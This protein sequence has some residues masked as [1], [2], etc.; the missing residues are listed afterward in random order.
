[1]FAPLPVE[2]PA[3]TRLSVRMGEPS[4]FTEHVA[5][6][7]PARLRQLYDEA[8]SSG[9]QRLPRFALRQ[10]PYA[11]QVP[12]APSLLTL[13][14]PLVVDYWQHQLPSALGR[15]GV[16][17]AR[18]LTPVLSVYEE[19]FDP[20]DEDFCQFAGLIERTLLTT[21]A[22]AV[23]PLRALQESLT[24]FR[25]HEAPSRIAVRLLSATEGLTAEVSRANLS[26]DVLATRLGLASFNAA[27]SLLPAT[28]SLAQTRTERLLEW[29][30][31]LATPVERSPARAAFVEAL[32][33]PWCDAPPPERLKRQ[34]SETLIQRL[35]D[36]RAGRSRAY[37]W[38]DV[39][40]RALTVFTRWLAQD[41]LTEF[42]RI[43]NETA[44]ET[45][46]YRE[47]FWLACWHASLIQE[48]WL[49]LGSDATELVRAH[50]RAG[51]ALSNRHGVLRGASKQQ[52][53]LL[54]RIGDLLLVEWSHSGALRAYPVDT[55]GIPQLYG[56]HYHASD[57]RL[58]GSLDFHGG[59]NQKT[60]LAHINS[61]QGI[62]QRKVRDFL[63]RHTG[64]FL[65]DAE[66]L[67]R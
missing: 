36:P 7:L 48:A 51:A 22:P 5:P 45:W 40:Q 38:R 52:S 32:L 37:H 47:R 20:D 33:L 46:R 16:R 65:T 4:S 63:R 21:D 26:P 6:E 50:A 59:L 19:A 2:L 24:Y 43:L 53:V 60:E 58:P 42:I 55:A 28:S 57:L 9:Y 66:I 29:S 64:V 15:G 54:L 3:L 17:A 39:S 25:I 12:G 27:L 44:D 1:M 31:H 14:R 56:E 30:R 67:H 34:I 13:H 10:L 11:W 49:V 35:G 18:W 23:V 41:S 61:A 8:A 62:W